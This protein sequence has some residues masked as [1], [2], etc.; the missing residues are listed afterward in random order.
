[1]EKDSLE[2]ALVKLR[3]DAKKSDKKFTQSIDLII[4][5]KAIKSKSQNSSIDAVTHL[6]H[7]VKEVKTCAFIDKDMQVQSA[8]NF[9]MLITKDDLAKYDKKQVRKVIKNHEF[10][11]AEAS[12]MPQ[13]AAKFGKQLAA[14]GKM[15][16]PKTNT[17]IT[18]SSNLKTVAESVKTLLKL[19]TSKNRAITIKIGDQKSEDNNLTENA[20]SVYNAVKSLLPNGDAGIKHIYLKTTMGSPVPI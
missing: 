2:K 13:V 5:L 6:P 11:F 7:K 1:M 4:T 3:E 17:I 12:I 8:G 16:N 20:L 14:K 18:P 9:S 19:N 10:F 15:P